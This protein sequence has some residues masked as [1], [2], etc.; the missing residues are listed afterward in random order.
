MQ[1]WGTNW[2]VQELLY[3]VVLIVVCDGFKTFPNE[4]INFQNRKMRDLIPIG[5]IIAMVEQPYNIAF[6][7]IKRLIHCP[8]VKSLHVMRRKHSSVISLS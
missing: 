3:M 6:L 2:D 4:K 8:P 5:K 1:L 7:P